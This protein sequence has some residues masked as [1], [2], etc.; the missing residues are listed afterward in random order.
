MRFPINID[1]IVD[2]VV[3]HIIDKVDLDK[4]NFDNLDPDNINLDQIKQVLDLD[5]LTK[6]VDVQSFVNQFTRDGSGSWNFMP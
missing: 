3:D 5:S 2:N 1:N 4:L 6:G